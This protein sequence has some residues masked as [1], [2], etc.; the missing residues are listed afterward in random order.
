MTVP[1]FGGN[2]LVKQKQ[3]TKIFM[4]NGVSCQASLF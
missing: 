3:L 2:Q 1:N 4:C